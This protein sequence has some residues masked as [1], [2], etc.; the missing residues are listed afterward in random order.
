MK[1]LRVLVVD[2]LEGPRETLRLTLQE[3]SDWEIRAQG[4][5]SVG[6][7]LVQF[8][9][10]MV[11]LDLKED[12]TGHGAGNTS[13][14]LIWARWFCPVV[15]YT[16]APELQEFKNN[17]LV[18]TIQKGSDTDEAVRTRLE[19]FIPQVEMIR[20]VHC[21]FD[22]RIREAL[23]DSVDYLGD[24][25]ETADGASGDAVLSRAVHRL[26]AARVD[27][28]ISGNGQLE[29]WERFVVPPLGEDLLTADLL[30]RGV[31]RW[32]AE[33][34]FRL[35]LT[36]SCDLARHGGNESKVKQVLVAQCEAMDNLQALQLR[37]EEKLGNK[38]KKERQRKKLKGMVREGIAGHYIP[39]PPLRGHVPLM[40]A[41][42]KR[43][44]LLPLDS[45]RMEA[46]G[47]DASVGP[48]TYCRVASTDSPFRE[49]VV[50]AYLRVTG[51]P[52]VPE[53]DVD[54]WVDQILRYL[55][56][57]EQT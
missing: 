25:I 10:D 14:D 38:R 56:T 8:R 4:F 9:P 37:P 22:A 15:V 12:S 19:E 6:D 18:A 5:D 16:A 36:P 45:I 48:D 17:P 28:G 42:L 47:S 50:W 51:R 33:S 23:R 24:Q 44:Q 31:A 7:V 49:M 3:E 53:V 11:V 20:G 26:V 40:A 34:T 43:L 29:G 32:G 54:D 13:F 30:Q 2:D 27:V 21:E 57:G 46:C 52:G 41:N 1:P 39:I 55:E 35:V